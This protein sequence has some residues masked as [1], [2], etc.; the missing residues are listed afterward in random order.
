M[1]RFRGPLVLGTALAA[2]I[3]AAAVP[4]PPGPAFLEGAKAANLIF[5]H[6]NGASGKFYLPEEMGAGV[7]VFDYDNDGDLDVFLVQGAASAPGPRGRGG[8]APPTSRLFRN[9]LDVAK[10][11]RRTLRFTDVTAKAGVGLVSQ[12]MGAAVGD[13]DNDGWVD[14][15][16]TTFGPD[17]LYRNNGN[18]TFTDVTREAGVSDP[19][20]SA[21]ASFLDY[22]RDGHLDL[23][24]TNYVAFTEADNRQCFDQ[25][26]APHYCPPGVYRP[27]PNRLYRNDGRG[28]FSNVTEAA[29]ISRADGSGL[30]VV[31]G[32]FNGDDWLDLYVANDGNPNQ[33][34]VNRQNGTFVDEGLLSGRATSM[35]TAT[36]ICS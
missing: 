7:A 36:R 32:D 34:W 35:P 4:Q 8:A 31:A 12:G 14:L 26:G 21:S 24:V 3:P 1:S 29:G 19:H 16:V 18:G 11:G 17:Y 9:D 5:T 13:Y 6:T 22:D 20:W 27:S 15:F 30:G 33:L 2:S 23:F 10:D 25:A 28:R